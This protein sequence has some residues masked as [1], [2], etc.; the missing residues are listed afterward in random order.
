MEL[1]TIMCCGAA[2]KSIKLLWTLNLLEYIFPP[3]HQILQ[4][5]KYPKWVT[6]LRWRFTLPGKQ[7]MRDLFFAC[8]IWE[9]LEVTELLRATWKTLSFELTGVSTFN[10]E[11]SFTVYIFS[12]WFFSWQVES[13]GFSPKRQPVSGFGRHGCCCR[14]PE[15]SASFCV[16]CSPYWLCSPPW[17]YPWSQ[18]EGTQSRSQQWVTLDFLKQFSTGYTEKGCTAKWGGLPWE[19]LIRRSLI[20]DEITPE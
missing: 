2:S 19:I 11:A 1:D 12:R 5:L 8:Q 20:L 7:Q 17:E 10:G 16:A 14:P 15:P 13:K 9:C 18:Q 3:L 4:S 6:Y